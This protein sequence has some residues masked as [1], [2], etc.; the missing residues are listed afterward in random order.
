MIDRNGGS[1]IEGVEGV[2]SQGESNSPTHS[3]QTL[4]V[5]GASPK[6]MAPKDIAR[7]PPHN[8]DAERMLLGSILQDGELTGGE[9]MGL[10]LPVIKRTDFYR[11]VH[12]RLYDVL[13]SLYD[14]GEPIDPVIVF[15]ECRRLGIQ[16]EIGGVDYL[17]S[18]YESV[19]SPSNAEEY[20]RI[21]RDKSL[22]RA[23]IITTD[24]IRHKAYT[25]GARG[26][27]LLEL[28]EARIFELGKRTEVDRLQSINDLVMEAMADIDRGGVDPNTIR[29]GFIDF[30][31]MT[32]GLRPGELIIVAGRP[33]MGKSTFALNVALNAAMRPREQGRRRVAI[34][35]LEMSAKNVAQNM[36]SAFSEVPGRFVREGR[37]LTP[38]HRSKLQE[39]AEALHGADIFID[40]SSQLTPTGL[41]AKA[42]RLKSK[43]GLD[44]IVVDYL[45]LMSGDSG[46]GNSENRQQEVSYISRTL[47]GI[48][49][50]LEVPVIAL[51]QLNRAAE[52]REG[53]RP[54]LSDLRESGAI[55]QDADVIA[56]LF[57]KDY[58]LQKAGKADD[59]VAAAAGIAEVILAKQRNGPTG[60][61]KLVFKRDCLRFMNLLN[62]PIPD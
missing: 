22:Q 57:R 6:E 50:E 28:A 34:F 47:K 61:V 53:N 27:E 25:G 35:S 18:L 48:A 29:S 39:A 40:D 32:G 5:D 38:T 1:P 26:D 12:G 24:D 42:R 31:N 19:A 14:R 52:N 58:Y 8:L 62:Q 33:S 15:E 7:V 2:A 43:P 20:A 59:E 37:F 54:K 11:G 3:S 30:D 49:R 55:E 13:K 17:V 36:L 51:S 56:L 9:K 41:R 23:L 16:D 60:V 4:V 21:V 46:T 45:Q 44:L 10:V